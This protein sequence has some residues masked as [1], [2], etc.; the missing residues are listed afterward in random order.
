MGKRLTISDYLFA[1]L[2]IF[3]IFCIIVAFFFGVDVGK[4]KAAEQYEVKLRSLMDDPP[5]DELGSYH[6]QHLVSFYYN[7][8]YPFR[9]FQTSWTQTIGELVNV[10]G[11]EARS[12]IKKLSKSAEEVYRSIEVMAIPAQSPLLQEAQTN[13]VRSLRLFLEA[14]ARAQSYDGSGR[15]I[16][17]GL[18]TDPYITD[19]IKYATT[20]QNQYYKAIV[21]WHESVVVELD[22]MDKM[23]KTDM[24]LDEWAKLPF[25]VQNS[26]VTQAMKDFEIFANYTPQDMTAVITSMVATGKSDT[27]SLNN[28]EEAVKLLHHTNAVRSGDFFK[29]RDAYFVDEIVPELPFYLTE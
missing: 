28:V 17:D 26:I 7:V 9:T 15:E 1:L 24:A 4:S 14:D 2:V 23:S 12:A 16:I 20:A 8:Y 21:Y 18:L 10:S 5:L 6:Q 29:Y 27:L 11:S 19:A 22:G 3:M 13:Y 25:N